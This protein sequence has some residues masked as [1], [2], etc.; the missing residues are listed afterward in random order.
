[1]IGGRLMG[2]QRLPGDRTAERIDRGC[3]GRGDVQPSD[4]GLDSQEGDGHWLAT[5]RG[6]FGGNADRDRRR[7]RVEADRGTVGASGKATG[8]DLR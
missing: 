5:H 1:V 7:D 3:G 2:R 4:R 8:A 6:S